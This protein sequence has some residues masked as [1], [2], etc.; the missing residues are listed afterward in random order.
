VIG[1]AF[2]AAYL[3]LWNAWDIYKWRGAVRIKKNQ[4]PHC[5]YAVASPPEPCSECGTVA[6]SWRELVRLSRVKR[7][8]A[9]KSLAKAAP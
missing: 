7:Q 3:F 9:L 8:S 1:A 6:P 4:C 2:L 5:G